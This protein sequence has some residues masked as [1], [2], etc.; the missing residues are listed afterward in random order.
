MSVEVYRRKWYNK[1]MVNANSRIDQKDIT[2]GK[3]LVLP[4]GHEDTIHLHPNDYLSVKGAKIDRAV[5]SVAGLSFGIAGSAV[6]PEGNT[7]STIDQIALPVPD[8]PNGS[9][10]ENI[11]Y[12]QYFDPI[13][14][15]QK[16]RAIVKIRNGSIN[17]TSVVAVDARLYNIDA[18]SLSA[19][20]GSTVNPITGSVSTPKQ[21]S[22]NAFITPTPSTPVVTF[23]RD[24]TDMSWGW[25]NS[26]GLGSY[27]DVTYEW[28]ISETNSPTGTTLFNGISNYSSGKALNIGTSGILREYRVSTR[29]GDLSKTSSPR[30]LR[31]RAVVVGSDNNIYYSNYSTPI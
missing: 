22:G 7:E 13:T 20:S 27:S 24:N 12:E 8:V 15:N 23:K 25:N 3:N 18:E 17:P 2:R 6:T 19:K 1:N 26:T 28:I 11:S 30:W 9:D 16:I 31:V 21:T 10:I 14:K 4:E 29:D 5:Y